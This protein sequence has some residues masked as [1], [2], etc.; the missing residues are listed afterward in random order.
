MVPT[1]FIWFLKKEQNFLRDGSAHRNHRRSCRDS[2]S[3]QILV[4]ISVFK[5]GLKGSRSQVDLSVCGHPEAVGQSQMVTLSQ[6]HRIS[7]HDWVHR[8]YGQ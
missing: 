5:T 4:L 3:S 7:V 8:N 1:A 2:L 6:V